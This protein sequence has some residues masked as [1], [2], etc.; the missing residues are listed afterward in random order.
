[1]DRVVLAA[2]REQYDIFS[3][4]VPRR[5]AIRE[6]MAAGVPC[7]VPEFESITNQILKEIQCHEEEV[8]GPPTRKR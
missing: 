5:V 3:Q 7:T 4:I 6:Q 2:M 8:R 1:M